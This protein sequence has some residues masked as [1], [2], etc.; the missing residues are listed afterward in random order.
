M[1]VSLAPLGPGGG[2]GFSHKCGTFFTG[3][4]D[5]RL[6]FSRSFVQCPVYVSLEEEHR[7]LSQT[8]VGN[9]AYLDNRVCL[10]ISVS[11]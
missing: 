7:L 1:G 2:E 4:L 5:N 8:A 9:L 3:C 10:L 11:L 6:D